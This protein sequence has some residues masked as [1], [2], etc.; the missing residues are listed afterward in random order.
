M[1]NPSSRSHYTQN[2]LQTP[3]Q[4][5]LDQ[6]PAP[7]PSTLPITVQLSSYGPPDCAGTKQVPPT[8]D[9]CPSLP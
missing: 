2:K 7:L 3:Q 9:L 8:S 4:T 6:V 5:P 1:L